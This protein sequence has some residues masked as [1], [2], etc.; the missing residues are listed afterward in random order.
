MQKSNFEFLKGVNDFMFSIARAAEKNYPDDPNTTLMKARI[1]GE[2]T[3][4]PPAKLL[5][6]EAP[7]NQYDF[8][9]ELGKIPFVDDTIL[10]VFHK[11]R[12]ID[13]Q[14]NKFVSKDK[15]DTVSCHVKPAF[16]DVLYTN[17][18]ANFGNAAVV[19]EIL[20]DFLITW[21]VMRIVPSQVFRVGSQLK[22]YSRCCVDCG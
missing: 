16:N 8:L 15:F 7:D 9:C 6:I 1:F 19:P 20:E 10:S 22:Y 2:A 13:F 21:N 3:A 18:G 4:K 11:L 12:K 14:S 17:I 5:D